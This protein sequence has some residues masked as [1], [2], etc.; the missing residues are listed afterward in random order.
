MTT[1]VEPQAPA[2]VEAID[3]LTPLDRCDRC[4]AAAIVRWRKGELLIDFCMHHSDSNGADLMS[5]KF[6]VVED[7]RSIL[8][9]SNT[10]VG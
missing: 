6:E 2:V 8:I 4:A 10:D 3:S 7:I 9:P 1:A 5:S